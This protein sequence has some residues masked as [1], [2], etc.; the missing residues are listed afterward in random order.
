[1]DREAID[2]MRTAVV[3]HPELREK[4]VRLV[5]L[6]MPRHGTEPKNLVQLDAEGACPMLETD[7]ACSIHRDHGPEALS[8]TCA[9]FPRTSLAVDGR[10]EVTGSLSCPELA[11]LTLLADDGLEQQPAPVRVLPR[12]YVGKVLDS[13]P[14]DVYLDAFSRVRATI[15]RLFERDEFPIGARLLFVA[16]LA[17]QVA[18]FFHAGQVTTTN[19]QRAMLKRRLEVELRAAED[20]EILSTLHADLDRFQ[21]GGQEVIAAAAALW[22]DRR[23]LTHSRRFA[24]VLGEA[25]A[26]LQGEH[27]QGQGQEDDHAV[28]RG[29]HLGAP[30]AAERRGEAMASSA[31]ER[32]ITP[33]RL[34]E[35]DRRRRALLEARVPG[36][37]D[38]ILGRYCRHYVLRNPYTDADSLLSYVGR[39]ALVL[40]AVRLV[41]TATPALAARFEQTPD[42]ALDARV[43]SQSAIEVIQTFTKA[44]SHHVEYL[45]TVHQANEKGAASGGVTFGRLVLFAKFV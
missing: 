18:E 6:G 7:G 1:L 28:A 20:P 15:L 12:A 42:R 40:A 26:S 37:L 23:R 19:G 43:V 11:R 39:L 36:A 2:R 24:Q 45:A 25:M 22:L 38:Q 33:E 35:I 31:R 44:I 5:V 3:H 41:W 9:V 27:E 32:T 8:T 21:G 13:D 17:A 10:L 4:L 29:G 16:N 34:W 30:A 14:L